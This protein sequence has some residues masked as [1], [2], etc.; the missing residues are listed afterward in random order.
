MFLTGSL[1][2][3]RYAAISLFIFGL[4]LNAQV[5][6]LPAFAN[7]YQHK[8][9]EDGFTAAFP[10]K[11]VYNVEDQ[12]YPNFKTTF[13]RY[14]DKS[15]K[16]YYFEV[17]SGVYPPALNDR[18]DIYN[19]MD[20]V[21]TAYFAKFG[22]SV[23][24]RND[25]TLGNCSG[26]E[27]EGVS[28]NGMP[29]KVRFF[30]SGQRFYQLT[31]VTQ[32]STTAAIRTLNHFL[33]SFAITGGC[34]DRVAAYAAPSD[35]IKHSVIEGTPDAASGW[36]RI[37]SAKDGLEM[38]MPNAA[39]LDEK[40]ISMGLPLTSRMFVSS[41]GT[42]TYYL[43]VT[44]DFPDGFVKPSDK[45]VSLSVL[46][47]NLAEKLAPIHPQITRV[48]D[49]KIGSFWGRE[50]SIAADGRIGMAQILMTAKKRYIALTSDSYENYSAA[51]VKMF[52]G[53]I[54]ISTN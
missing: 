41:S 43:E 52:L 4:T 30:M 34:T 25:I 3:L 20:T 12:N 39:T 29:V 32:Y 15:H 13:H 18:D 7:W 5:P 14:I 9:D 31:A 6:R 11:P 8:S 28:K 46:E 16:D 40:D 22:A 49:L 19:T 10:S 23:Q 35:E 33:D 47:K 27:I 2:D 24:N 48:R 53:S 50:Y 36:R 51:N 21:L 37:V 42:A 26:K 44:G 45:D 1:R 17:G 54:R 38:L